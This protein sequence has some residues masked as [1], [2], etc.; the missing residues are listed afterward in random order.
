MLQSAIFAD[1]QVNSFGI[2]TVRFTPSLPLMSLV[3]DSFSAAREWLRAMAP[4]ND[5][6]L[7]NDHLRRDIGLVG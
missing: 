2:P 5:V 3:R 4:G 1:L 6:S 7:L